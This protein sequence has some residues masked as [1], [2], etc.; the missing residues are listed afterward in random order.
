[1]RYFAFVITVLLMM[2]AGAAFGQENATDNETAAY[3]PVDPEIAVIRTKVN[4]I[5]EV[6]QAD[7][8]VLL[9]TNP[10]AQGTVAVS[11]SITPEGI[12]TDVVIDCPE[13]LSDLEASITEALGEL[14][15]EPVERTEDLPVTIP[16]DLMPPE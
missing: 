4:D 13:E 3:A 10:E 1:M 15:F 2:V 9:E 5:R 14:E 11:F 6:I 12:V 16:F 7:Y 8:E